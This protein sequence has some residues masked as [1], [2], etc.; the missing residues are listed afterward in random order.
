MSATPARVVVV[1]PCFNEAERLAP[2]AFLEFAD[3]SA[4]VTFLFVDDGSRDDTPA[5][6]D[7][8]QRARPHAFEVIRLARN[9]GKAEAVR[10]G[11][12]KA[13]QSDAAYVAF[14]DADLA[15]PLESIPAFR[16]VFRRRPLTEI[17]M[18]S[19]VRLVGRDIARRA[20]RHYVGRVFATAV[21]VTLGVS[22]YDSQCGA[23]MFRATETVRAVFAEPFTSRWIFDV[24]ILARFIRWKRIASDDTLGRYVYELPLDT[25]RDVGGSK[26]R[27]KDFVRAGLDLWRIRRHSHADAHAEFARCADDK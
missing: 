21:A 19:R 10:R 25:W 26:L 22:V 3:H 7:E 4:D 12:V 1:V 6:L 15:T 18:G 14:W 27:A 16:A 8:M 20:V 24:E 2:K 13:L 23:K 17:V 11:I 5:V 9:M